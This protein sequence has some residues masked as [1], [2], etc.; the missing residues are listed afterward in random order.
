MKRE[1]LRYNINN[2][3]TKLMIKTNK[4][5]MIVFRDCPGAHCDRCRASQLRESLIQDPAL[6]HGRTVRRDQQGAEIEA[7][8]PAE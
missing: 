1:G 6:H 5:D 4:G 8:H 3:T 7:D 2:V